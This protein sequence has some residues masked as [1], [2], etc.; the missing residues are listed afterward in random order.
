MDIAVA[1]R[2]I[3]LALAGAV[4]LLAASA[5]NSAGP[6]KPK[7]APFNLYMIDDETLPGGGPQLTEIKNGAQV[8][9][10]YI[11][12]QLGGLKGRPLKLTACDPK[13]DP[14]ATATCANEGVAL[15]PL[16]VVGGAALSLGTSAAPIFDAASIP[17][18]TTPLGGAEYTSHVSFPLMAST[19]IEPYN[20]GNYLI[21]IKKAKTI[22]II[23]P[24]PA[25]G[26][27]F[28]KIGSRAGV[29]IVKAI[30]PRGTVD[31]TSVAVQVMRENPDYVAVSAGNGDF[32]QIVRALEAQGL[33][34]S[35]IISQMGAVD[36]G[37]VFDVLGAAANGITFTD[38]FDS[39]DNTK[40]PEV[41]T[42][43]AAVRK[44]MPAQPVEATYA[45]WGFANVMTV[46]NVAKGLRSPSAKTLAKAL[47]TPGKS[48][49]IFMGPRLQKPENAL[50]CAAAIRQPLSRVVQYS[51]GKLVNIT[52]GYVSFGNP[53]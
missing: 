21:K 41:A 26:T 31:F 43:R 14:G 48:W 34:G 29:K 22:G 28:D 23:A 6:P 52:K 40:N 42:Y 12:R 20:Y 47:N 45:Q 53:C 51:N 36:K 1:R 33:S 11:N 17:M 19:L 16:A 25:V 4:V 37:L 5:A 32:V 9:V 27:I 8:A 44:Y 24:N 10:D 46:Y 39:Y 18:F 30:Y 2:T 38:A 3:V 49:P 15:K 50:V 35:R 7:G 13:L